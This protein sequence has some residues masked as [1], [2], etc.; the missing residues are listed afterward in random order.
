MFV[1]QKFRLPGS[2]ARVRQVDIMKWCQ[3][4]RSAGLSATSAVLSLGGIPW[5]SL[6]PEIW[7]GVLSYFE[8]INFLP[9]LVGLGGVLRDALPAVESKSI[10]GKKSHLSSCLSQFEQ[11]GL[12][13]S[14]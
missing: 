12:P 14:H 5:P 2:S 8:G 1:C 11:L 10:T 7:E 6:F 13:S 3:S 9:A 4:S